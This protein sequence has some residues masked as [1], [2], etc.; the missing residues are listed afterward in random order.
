MLHVLVC[1]F[2]DGGKPEGS[3]TENGKLC[4][5]EA[6]FPPKEARC[7]SNPRNSMSSLLA[8]LSVYVAAPERVGYTPVDFVMARVL[9]RPTTRTTR[10]SADVPASSCNMMSAGLT[11]ALDGNCLLCRIRW[12]DALHVSCAEYPTGTARTRDGMRWRKIKQA[13]PV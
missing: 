9:V 13:S 7:T 2:M 5:P 11:A 8:L 1:T 12:G 4:A 3:A 6:T 10:A